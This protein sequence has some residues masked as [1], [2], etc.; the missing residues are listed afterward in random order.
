MKHGFV[1]AFARAWSQPTPER[2]VAL[3]HPDVVLLQPH[4]HSIHGRANALK[5]F[6]RMLTWLPGLHGAVERWS[7]SGDAVFVEWQMKLPLGHRTLSIP[8]V[9]RFRLDNGLAI[10]RVVYFDRLTLIQALLAHP[11]LWPGWAR[12]RFGSRSS[13]CPGSAAEMLESS[14]HVDPNQQA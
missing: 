10:E 5:E 12:Y 9:D 6:R 4:L 3:L 7:A 13:F 8:A 11:R 14:P 2:L 1:D